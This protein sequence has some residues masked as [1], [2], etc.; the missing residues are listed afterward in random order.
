[1]KEV[2]T[3]PTVAFTWKD[4]L[5]VGITIPT[6]IALTLIGMLTAGLLG[7]W[8][9]RTATWLFGRL[10]VIRSLYGALKQ[11]VETVLASRSDVFRDCVLFEYPRKGSWA[12]GLLTGKTEG[13][14]QQLTEEDVVN[15]FLPT[16]PNPTSGFLMFVPRKETIRLTMTVEEGLKMVVSGGLV[17]PPDRGLLPQE[18]ESAQL[19]ASQAARA[20]S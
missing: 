9:L 7:R 6:M 14:I 10:P 1:M 17:V 16:T 13:Q 8:F 11:I 20:S 15:V 5:V 3:P 19:P 2:V 18:P 12:I 4:L